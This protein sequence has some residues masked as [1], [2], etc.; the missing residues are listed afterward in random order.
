MVTESVDAYVNQ[1]I[2]IARSVILHDDVVDDYFK[3][4]KTS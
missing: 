2:E 3:K 1:D 4:I